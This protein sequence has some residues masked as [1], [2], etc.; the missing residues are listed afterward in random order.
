MT[1]Y[2]RNTNVIFDKIFSFIKFLSVCSIPIVYIT[3]TA[4]KDGLIF[5]N[6]KLVNYDE[7][8]NEL[9]KFDTVDVKK[10]EFPV[11]LEADSEVTNGTIVKLFDVIRESG[12]SA[13]NLRTTTEK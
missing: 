6:D 2:L 12:Y 8:K 13:I 5:F 3:I 4:D 7:L 10:I 11:S 9:V 1:Y